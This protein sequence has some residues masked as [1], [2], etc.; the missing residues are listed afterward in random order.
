MSQPHRQKR[1]DNQY[2]KE[3]L[4]AHKL[5]EAMIK[6]GIDHGAQFLGTEIIPGC[7]VDEEMVDGCRLYA[8]TMRDIFEKCTD[9]F[10]EDSIVFGSSSKGYVDSWAY[11]ENS[12]TLYVCDFK[13]GRRIVDVFE[14]YQLAIYDAALIAGRML[15][16][17]KIVNIVVQPRAQHRLGPVRMWE[18][19]PAVLADIIS[20]I[21]IKAE[22][23]LSESPLCVTGSH[24][25]DCEARHDCEAASMAAMSAVDYVASATPQGLTSDQMGTEAILLR[26]VQEAIKL[27]LAGLETEIEAK[28]RGGEPVKGWTMT[29]STGHLEWI[30][31]PEDVAI[32]G[33]QLGVNVRKPP[34]V[35]T[36]T[37]A[38][39][40]GFNQDV[41]ATITRRPSRGH[42]LTP[43]NMKE[44]RRKFSQG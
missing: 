18:T 19:T 13:Y 25:M 34:A 1:V 9:S 5:G 37:Q 44:V 11:C 7:V 8:Q 27:R 2:S 39:T 38:K 31:S 41:L 30:I 36:P 3:G 43:V 29:E 42:K 33:D 28:L 17:Q 15:D 32:L 20:H 24:C 4:A 26:R 22:E 40:A 23:A 21:N 35:I 16:V 10:T 6:S 14:N 12:K